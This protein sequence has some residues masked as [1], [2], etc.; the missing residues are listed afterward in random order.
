MNTKKDG[1]IITFYSYK[2]GTGRTML[3]ANIAWILASNGK[4]VL[5]IDWDL[6]APGLHRYFHPFLLDKDLY[7]TPGLIDLLR[8]YENK[9][10]SPSSKDVEKDQN[11]WYQ[12][13]VNLAR[14]AIAVRWEYFQNGSIKFLGAGKQD[15][16]YSR[17]VNSFN[18]DNFYDRLGGGKFLK[19]AREE[20]K[21]QFDYILIDSRTGISDTSGICTLQMPDILVVCFT[22]NTQSIEGASAVANS[23]FKQWAERSDLYPGKRR[24]WPVLT[25]VELSEKDKLDTSIILTKNK[26]NHFLNDFSKTKKETYWGGIQ[27]PHIPYFAFEEILAVFK[28]R[29]DDELSLLAPIQR[30]VSY[31]TVGEIGKVVAPTDKERSKIINIFERKSAKEIYD[32]FIVYD[33]SDYNEVARLCDDLLKEYELNLWLDEWNLEPNT[34]INTSIKQAIDN[35]NSCVV[36]IG[37]DSMWPKSNFQLQLSM[38][39]YEDDS[40]FRVIPVLL[41]SVKKIPKL[42]WNVSNNSLIDLRV[43]KDYQALLQL[44]GCIKGFPQV[45]RHVEPTIKTDKPLVYISYSLKD[46]IWKDRLKPQLDALQMAEQIVVWDDRDIDGGDKWYPKFEEAMS[47]ATVAVCLI[48]ENYLASE[49]CVKEEIPYLLN[50]EQENNMLFIPILISPCA[51]KA[52]RWLKESQMLPRDGKSIIK[53]FKDDWS[54]AFA[55]VSDL[56]LKKINDLAYNLPAATIKWAVPEKID[57]YRLPQT[58][59]T[60]F[61]REKEL[62]Q[63]DDAWKSDVVNIISFIAWG[64]VGKSTLINKWLEYMEEDYYKDAEQVFAWSFYSQGTSEKVSSADTFISEALSWFGDSDPTKGSAWDKGERL[65]ELIRQKKTLLILDG[66]EPLQSSHQ[67]EKGK[68]KDQG[69]AALLRSLARNNNGLCIITSREGVRD[70]SKYKQ[71]VEQLS[72][73]K[74]SANAGRALLRVG[75]VNGSDHELEAAVK[76]FGYHALAIKLLPVYL[77]NLKGNLISEALKISDL[78]IPVNKGKHP[79]RVIDALSKR[80][81]GTSEGDLLK[82]LGFFDRPADIEA[83]EIIIAQPVIENLTEKLCNKGKATFLQAINTLRNENLL[84]GEN[85]HRP[86]TLDCHPLIRE[87]FGQILQEQLPAAWKEAHARLYEYYKRLPEK[88]LP[89]TLEEMEPLFAAVMHGCLAGKHQEAL[90][91]VYWNRIK[92]GNKYYNIHKLGAIG[93]DLYYLSGFFET[94][95]D[96]PASDLTDADKA[97]TLSWAGFALRAVCRLSEAIQPMKAELEMRIKDELWKNA[98]IA[99]SNLS[100]VYLTLGDV[101]SA[102]EYGKQCVIFADRSGDGFLMGS[103]RVTHADALFQAGETKLAETLF[104]EAENIQTKRQPGYTYLDS[105]RGF[106]YCDL[107]LSL[108]KYQEVV[109]RARTALEIAER[110]NWLLDIAHAKLTIGKALMHLGNYAEA[111]KYL[112]HAVNGLREAGQQDDLPRGLLARA[113]LY[114]HQ[115]NFAKCWADLD[116]A[117]EIAEY[118]QMR[119]FLTDYHLEACRTINAQTSNSVSGFEIIENGETLCLTT[120]QMQARFKAHFKEAERLIGETGYHRRDGE[121]GKMRELVV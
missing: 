65:A 11:N 23:I 101:V 92:R 74:L 90:H 68:I 76:E 41:K 21:K 98:A 25:R 4:H 114:R 37:K 79:R 19:E 14:G 42:P 84:A 29:G 38:E 17:K 100:G 8:D 111:E 62:T 28:E 24:I 119:L 82:L 117:R 36:F 35:S 108:G 97:V 67:F 51:W 34:S 64:G 7:H 71:G 18:W 95:W 85:K 50:R 22:P 40:S 9:A 15:K 80:Y 54:V 31:L 105:L 56:I 109:D 39:K 59:S 61:G 110:N 10:L 70:I 93:A 60:L 78:D 44:E 1:K 69:L 13:E 58:G 118:G 112:L 72:L 88:E 2:G 86:S 26:F 49:F 63:L 73:E 52:F 91:D 66:M 55:E 3:L 6:E 30:L 96:K 57:I 75:G 20:L 48:S 89:D 87:H 116:E 5:V 32:A 45:K 103:K 107:L 99:A 46:E 83:I 43:L 115:L 77:H 16:H 113:T 120:Q 104:M 106:W 33:K 27:I 81:E 12:K 121:L 94:L 102:Q 53:D 47:Q